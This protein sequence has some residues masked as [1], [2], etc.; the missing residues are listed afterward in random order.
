MI[1][2]WWSYFSDTFG[3]PLL[4]KQSSHIIVPQNLQCL[5]QFI[6]QTPVVPQFISL[7]QVDVWHSIAFPYHFPII[8]LS[9]PYHFPII[10]LISPGTRTWSS[11]PT[12][13][14]CGLRTTPCGL[15]SL[16]LRTL[17]FQ[18][19]LHRKKLHGSG[20]LSRERLD[21][22]WF[23]YFYDDLCMFMMIMIYDDDLWWFMYFFSCI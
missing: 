8:S 11:D 14:T 22:W 9:F 10:S 21:L 18:W 2:N 16:T 1:P 5:Y 7:I 12:P 6:L 15:L 4:Y 17:S 3:E 23:M 20:S 19:I 13:K